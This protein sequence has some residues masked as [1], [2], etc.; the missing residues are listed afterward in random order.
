MGFDLVLVYHKLSQMKSALLQ[1][2]IM[3]NNLWVAWQ[4]QKCCVHVQLVALSTP[5][6]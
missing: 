2:E 1:E 4:Y 5:Y 3:D 6:Y